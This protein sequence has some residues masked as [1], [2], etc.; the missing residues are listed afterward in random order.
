MVKEAV[1]VIAAF[2]PAQPGPHMIAH[3]YDLLGCVLWPIAVLLKIFQKLG[4]NHR[5]SNSMSPQ[6]GQKLERR[7]TVRRKHL[8]VASETTGD[9]LLPV[10]SD[11]PKN[12]MW[13][14]ILLR[15]CEA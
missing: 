13:I 14:T 4:L 2:S 5:P 10:H 15:T 1:I 8:I 12:H 9:F 11:F 3:F 7:T 6:I